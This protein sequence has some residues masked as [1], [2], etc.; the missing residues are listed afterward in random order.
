MPRA[1]I[2]RFPH[3][4]CHY[5]N[6]EPVLRQHNP[7]CEVINEPLLRQSVLGFQQPSST[8]RLPRSR[9]V[10]TSCSVVLYEILGVVDFPV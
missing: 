8:T 6:R 3:I 5:I 4:K 1:S 2:S 10:A 7:R 9:V